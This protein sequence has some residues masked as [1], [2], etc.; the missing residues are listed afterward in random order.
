MDKSSF[1]PSPFITRTIPNKSEVALQA[2]NT[3]PIP[4]LTPHLQLFSK[5][6]K[7]NRG[8]DDFLGQFGV[9]FLASHRQNGFFVVAE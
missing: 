1:S 9:T 7:K 4:L 2:S 8:F 6:L 5:K 3:P